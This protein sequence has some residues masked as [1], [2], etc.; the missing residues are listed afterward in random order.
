VK[1]R[2]CKSISPWC[3]WEA[4][5]TLEYHGGFSGSSIHSIS[6]CTQSSQTNP[7][8]HPD[9]KSTTTTTVI[10]QAKPRQ[11]SS[12]HQLHSRRSLTCAAFPVALRAHFF[13]GGLQYPTHT[14]YSTQPRTPRKRVYPRLEAIGWAVRERGGLERITMRPVRWPAGWEGMGFR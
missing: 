6:S 2:A 14:R 13:P 10:N 12:Q 9:S 1:L 8:P 3:I 7:R 11:P 4:H 5:H